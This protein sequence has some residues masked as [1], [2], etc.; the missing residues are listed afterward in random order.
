[1]RSCSA[2]VPVHPGPS[3]SGVLSLVLDVQRAEVQHCHVHQEDANV[4]LEVSREAPSRACAVTLLHGVILGERVSTHDYFFTSVM[5]NK[6]MLDSQRYLRP[7][8]RHG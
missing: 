8:S 5:V 2:A 3:A 4:E 7:S 1:M 6:F